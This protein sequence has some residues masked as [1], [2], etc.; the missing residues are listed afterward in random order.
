MFKR[1]Y[2]SISQPKLI[3]SFLKDKRLYVFI[4]ILFLS[5]IVTI[6]V[7]IEHSVQKNFS[8]AVV[9]NIENTLYANEV[10]GTI[11]NYQLVKEKPETFP[12]NETP[13]YISFNEA[14][15]QLNLA[16]NFTND[17]LEFYI[18]PTL[19]KRYT[20]T[21]LGIESLNFNMRS[22][23]DRDILKGLLET[24]FLDI[25]PLYVT[26]M[27]FSSLLSDIYT[28]VILVLISV[29]LYSYNIPKLKMRY[30][31]IMASYGLTIFAVSS[32]L[33]N[34]YHLGFIRLIGVLLGLTFTRRAYMYLIQRK[35]EVSV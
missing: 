3:G 17:A 30:R 18:G 25:K 4:Y 14:N 29:W 8:P 22:N 21:E 20:Y 27:T 5:L 28:Y 19:Y 6:P 33:A 11:I 2:V 13:F 10:E 31:F 1:F 26:A 24:V 15:K 7:F 23:V 35:E 16:F 9:K 32:L 12:I 34:L